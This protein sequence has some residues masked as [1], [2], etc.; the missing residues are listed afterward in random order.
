MG[1]NEQGKGGPGFLLFFFFY[2]DSHVAYLAAYSVDFNT[3]LEFVFSD[4]Q[5]FAHG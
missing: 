5:V 4:W 3:W 2:S 1:L